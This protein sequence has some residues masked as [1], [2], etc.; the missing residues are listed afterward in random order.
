[1]YR[2]HNSG[3]DRKYF[4]SFLSPYFLSDNKKAVKKIVIFFNDFLF[5]H[6][7]LNLKLYMFLSFVQRLQSFLDENDTTIT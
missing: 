4:D 7:Y 3:S 5:K 1:M 2:L 6:S